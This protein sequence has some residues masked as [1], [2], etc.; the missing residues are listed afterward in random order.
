MARRPAT[1]RPPARRAP[2]V[3]LTV[4]S[5]PRFPLEDALQKLAGTKRLLVYMHDNPDPDALAAASGLKRLIEEEVGAE[6]TLALGGIVG[7]AEN[8]AMVDVVR[9]D[10]V[11][12]EEIVLGRFDK[13]AIVD[14]QP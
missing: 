6:A 12:L 5:P 10:L 14:S 3:T 4:T 2:P 9:I 8:R 11:P 7:R 1:S 13:I